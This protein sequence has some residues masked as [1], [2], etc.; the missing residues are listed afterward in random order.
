VDAIVWSLTDAERP[1]GRHM[2]VDELRRGIESMPAGDYENL[3]YYAKWLRSSIA[4]MAEKGL[5]DRAQVERRA[6]ELAAEHEREHS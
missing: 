4:I 3:G 6:R 5:I 1:G 2:T